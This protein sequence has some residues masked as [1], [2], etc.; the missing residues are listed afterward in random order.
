MAVVIVPKFDKASLL[1]SLRQKVERLNGRVL[2]DLQVIGESFV[3]NARNNG[4]YQDRTGNLRSSIGYIILKDGKQVSG[5]FPGDKSD[6]VQKAEAMVRRL[7]GED[8]VPVKGYVLIVVAGMD[9]AWAVETGYRGDREDGPMF[10]TPYDVLSNSGEQA[11]KDLL[12]VIEH[13]QK[14]VR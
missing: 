1:K 8:F 10:V 2:F 14:A 11:K 13:Y 12:E 7:M 9:Y 3:T 6:G 5:A 4:E